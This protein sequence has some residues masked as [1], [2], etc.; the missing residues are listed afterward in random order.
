MNGWGVVIISIL[1][2]LGVA[3]FWM[4][5]A[6]AGKK[7]FALARLASV[8]D[9]TASKTLLK[10]AL[11]IPEGVAIDEGRGKICL[12]AGEQY[13]VFGFS[14]LVESEVLVDGVSQTKVSRLGQVAGI[15]VGALALGPAGAVIGGLS[16]KTTTQTRV[17]GVKL[18]LV[19]DDLSCPVHIINFMEL[20]NTGGTIPAVALQEASAWHDLLS[21]II[22]RAEHGR[23]QEQASKGL[24]L[25]PNSLT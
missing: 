14:D 18:K 12:I 7:E 24:P 17:D 6:A 20:K 8:P 16:A 1:L 2:V 4:V 3:G 23:L 11:L 22:R 5:Q 13:R 25:S 19:V 10:C 21:V 9:F 15:A